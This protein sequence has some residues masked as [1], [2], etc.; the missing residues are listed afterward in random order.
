MWQVK[1]DYRLYLNV[2]VQVNKC[3]SVPLPSYIWLYGLYRILPEATNWELF[4]Y[5]LGSFE[6]TRL[7][8]VRI[9][10]I[11]CWQKILYFVWICHQPQRVWFQQFFPGAYLS[12]E[13][14]SKASARDIAFQIIFT[15]SNGAK[16]VDFGMYMNNGS[17]TSPQLFLFSNPAA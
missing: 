2:L 6:S 17:Y 9:L 16:T 1:L 15:G 13:V 7:L 11:G 5:E 14:V 8:C 12:K 3:S 4:D 10:H